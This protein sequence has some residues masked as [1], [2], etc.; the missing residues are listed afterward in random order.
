[1]R[2]TCPTSRPLPL[3]VAL[4]VAVGATLLGACGGPARTPPLIVVGID[5]GEWSVI[6]K[7]WDAGGLPNLARLA[8]EGSTARLATDYGVSPVI[9]TTIATGYAP[10]EH[11]ITGFA[12]PGPHGDVPVSSSLRRVPALW[13]LASLAGRRVA[14]LGWYATWPAERVNG[15]VVSDH[16]MRTELDERLYP[17]ERLGE[18]DA[19]LRSILARPGAE[20]FPLNPSRVGPHGERDLLV[21]ELAPEVAA[22]GYDLVLAYFRSV[23]HLS[24]LFWDHYEPEHYTAVDPRDTAAKAML[25]P[26]AYERVDAVVGRIRQAAP[27]ANLV[28]VSDHGFAPTPGRRRVALDMDLLLERLGFLVRD[29][30]GVDV[31]RSRAFSHGSSPLQARKTVRL[32]VRGAVPGGAVEPERVPELRRELLGA[33]EGVTYAGGG[34]TFAVRT[35]GGDPPEVIAEVLA[36]GVSPTLYAAGRPVAGLTVAVH[37]IT[38]G[39]AAD[40]HGV[41]L[42]AGPS[43]APRADLTGIDIHDLAPT[44]LYALGLP[45]AED[46]PGEVIEA[47]FEARFRSRHPLRTVATWRLPVE[48]APASS[49]ADEQI[50]E[51]LR[52]LGYLQ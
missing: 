19:R 24:H 11:G 27:D 33:L 20:L 2:A 3:L 9:W 1:M 18:I 25:I 28:V 50:L 21:E 17:A 26:A 8:A 22:Q 42:A 31:A 46:F 14:V 13:N 6:E 39:H 51:E 30:R 45:V 36:E 10:T 49:E 34:P 48:V 35:G 29:E 52:A 23:D 40:H 16:V 15:L 4:A 32:A 43:I 41:F 38:A 7:L 37:E 5:G 47:L 12:V 44:L